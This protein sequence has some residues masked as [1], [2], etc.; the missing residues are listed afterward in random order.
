VAAELGIQ[1]PASV[2]DLIPDIF[3]CQEVP[4]TYGYGDGDPIEQMASRRWFFHA[5]EDLP[6]FEI[7]SGIYV[8]N[9]GQYTQYYGTV[10][11]DDPDNPKYLHFSGG[12]G[13]PFCTYFDIAATLYATVGVPDPLPD[14]ETIF[15]H[16][17]PVPGALWLL[18]SAFVALLGIR[19][20]Y[21]K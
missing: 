7:F 18:G 6:D 13:I 12:Q 9:L 15:I 20:K 3:V 16:P 1:D 10:T 2:P 8:L 14:P 5:G 21:L 11:K 19:R 4:L 17:T